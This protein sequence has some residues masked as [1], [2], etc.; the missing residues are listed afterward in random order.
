MKKPA[1]DKKETRERK[2]H[3]D[4]FEVENVRWVDG[5]NGKEGVAFF[6]LIYQDMKVYNCK[7]VSGSN[8]DFVS[9]PSAKGSDGKY[10]NQAWM[11][12]SENDTKRI[13]ELVEAA[14]EK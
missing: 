9:F 5:K 13:I 6:S 14:L 1:N 7:I 12:L 10:Y 2:D 4:V 3:G 11:E 8:G